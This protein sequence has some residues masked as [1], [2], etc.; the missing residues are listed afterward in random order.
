M[1]KG[2]VVVKMSYGYEFFQFKFEQK[3]SGEVGIDI[4][5]LS[6]STEEQ[7]AEM[8]EKMEAIRLQV[9]LEVA[10]RLIAMRHGRSNGKTK[11]DGSRPQ[12]G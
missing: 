1:M 10:Y 11:V 5:T 12:E 6:E 2:V 9:K 8:K 7:L 3:D 4:L